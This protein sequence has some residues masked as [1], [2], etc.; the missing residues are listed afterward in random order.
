MHV[1]SDACMHVQSDSRLQVRKVGIPE[2]KV[3]PN[4]GAIALGYNDSDIIYGPFITGF[5]ALYCSVT[6]GLRLNRT[7]II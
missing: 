2:H 4:G 6:G 1:Q 7:H 5:S 3:N